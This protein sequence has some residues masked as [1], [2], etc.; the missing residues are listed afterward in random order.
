M[1]AEY[2]YKLTDPLE[3]RFKFGQFRSDGDM[4]PS[5]FP[6]RSYVVEIQEQQDG[7]VRA[8]VWETKNGV[9]LMDAKF[10]KKNSFKGERIFNSIAEVEAFAKQVLQFAVECKFNLKDYASALA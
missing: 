10:D 4:A 5:A 9:V 6:E 8:N 3:Y 2:K 1:S 7:A